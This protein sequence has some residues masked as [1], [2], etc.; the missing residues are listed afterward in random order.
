MDACAF[1]VSS[2]NTFFIVNKNLSAKNSFSHAH[3]LIKFVYALIPK[4]RK[5]KKKAI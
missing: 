1:A 4:K 5:K 2:N 3:S